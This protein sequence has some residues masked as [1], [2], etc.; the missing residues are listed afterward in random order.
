[1]IVN[2]VPVF[3]SVSNVIV[4]FSVS[5]SF[6]ATANPKPCPLGLVVNSGL[7]RFFFIS[8]GM[9]EPVSWMLMVAFAFLRVAL[10]V[11]VP[12]LGIA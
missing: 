12:P 7:K 1:M 5:V 11:K 2:V 8:S 3:F 6:F 4:P 10:S 9:P